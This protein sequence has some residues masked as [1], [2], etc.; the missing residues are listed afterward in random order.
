MSQEDEKEVSE[1][2][3]K[4]FKK[5]TF[6]NLEQKFLPEGEIERKGLITTK[7]VAKALEIDSNNLTDEDKKLIAF[8]QERA[9]KVFIIAVHCGIYKRELRTGLSFL[10]ARIEDGLAF[11]DE[12]LPIKEP[13]SGLG[14]VGSTEGDEQSESGESSNS[15]PENDEFSEVDEPSEN[16]KS[17][18]QVLMPTPDQSSELRDDRDLQT[19]DRASQVWTAPRILD[20][21]DKQWRFLSPVFSPSQSNYDLDNNEILPFTKKGN[22]RKGAF[23]QVFKVKI[24]QGHYKE[25]E[26]PVSWYSILMFY[27]LV[28]LANESL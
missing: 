19:F 7:A 27:L 20:F 9:T 23:G 25:L 1:K 13:S 26:G 22:V 16:R 14:A 17:G 2:L 12:S 21:Y 10:M 3:I 18:N 6:N 8:V 24:F 28:R 4:I 15:L 5:S 11:T